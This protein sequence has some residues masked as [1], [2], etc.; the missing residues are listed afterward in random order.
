MVCVPSL[1]KVY[2]VGIVLD[3]SPVPANGGIDDSVMIYAVIPVLSLA[4][5]LVMGTV[6]ELEVEGMM[7][8]EIVGAEV[9]ASTTALILMVTFA[10]ADNGVL[11]LS[12]TFTVK[13]R[14]VS[15]EN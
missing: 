14:V 4:A 7:N 6:N 3:Q 10:S 13:T 5:K 9:S 15:F 8:D 11:A 12:V 1:V 2:D